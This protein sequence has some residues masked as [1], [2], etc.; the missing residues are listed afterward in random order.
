MIDYKV[1]FQSV[2]DGISIAF[3]N[4]REVHKAVPFLN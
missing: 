3:I 2:I 1:H 4:V